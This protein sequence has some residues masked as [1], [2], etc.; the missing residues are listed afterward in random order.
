V[1]LFAV[2][3]WVLFKALYEGTGALYPSAVAAALWGWHPLRVQSVA[4]ISERKD[5]LAILFG[6]CALLAYTRYCR[7][8]T[9]LRYLL[10]LLAAAASL[11]SKAM[12]VTLPAVLILWDIWPMRRWSRRDARRRI[13]EKLP[14]LALCAAASALTFLAQSRGGAITAGAVYSPVLRL[15]NAIAAYARYLLKF[16][17]PMDLAAYYPF[18]ARGWS[19]NDIA[20]SALVL[21]SITGCVLLLRR[22][23]PYL[24]IGWFWY[25]GMMVP[26]IGI[27]Q[28]GS[29]SIADRYTLA[30]M[31][32]ISVALTWLIWETM[33]SD[34][35]IRAGVFGVILL[36]FAARTWVEIGYWRDTFT[37]FAR[38]HEVTGGSFI[39]HGFLGTEFARRKDDRTAELHF[40]EALCLNPRYAEVHFNLGNLL[41]RRQDFAGSAEHFAQAVK[42]MPGLAEGYNNLGVSLARTGRMR[43][44]LEALR[45]A[46]ELRPESAEFR[47]NFQ[48]AEAAMNSSVPNSR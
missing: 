28:V 36:A 9:R 48:A 40:R 35:T 47:R 14:I 20:I 16:I 15:Q 3:V 44:A 45:R 22:R 11:M 41:M 33:P 5:V 24:A 4:W 23:R 46:S 38:A 17:W 25:L 29:Q 43:E 32:G 6:L 1:V 26:M 27:V 30:P 8:P 37:L 19:L 31:I 2:S 21:V 39:S 18:P 10:V 13:I 7:Q 42:Y 34:R 12:W